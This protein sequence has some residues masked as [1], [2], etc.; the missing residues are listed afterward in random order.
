MDYSKMIDQMERERFL[1][2]KNK[3]LMGLPF[4][5]SE[6]IFYHTRKVKY[7]GPTEWPAEPAPNSAREKFLQDKLEQNNDQWEEELRKKGLR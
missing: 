4:T 2:I 1:S 5:T 3:F 6:S 7:E